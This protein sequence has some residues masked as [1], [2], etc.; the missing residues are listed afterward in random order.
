MNWNSFGFAACPLLWAKGHPPSRHPTSYGIAN[1]R[2]G[3]FHLPQQASGLISCRNRR[4][5]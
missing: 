3:F 2:H 4:V 5:V 1:G